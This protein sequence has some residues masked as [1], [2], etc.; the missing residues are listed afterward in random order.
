MAVRF[1]EMIE[2]RLRD[3]AQDAGPAHDTAEVTEVTGRVRGKIAILG[4]DVIMTGGTLLA[5]RRA[6]LKEHG[7]SEV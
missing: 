3:H 1:A 2:R 7:A 6:A 5:E 4:D